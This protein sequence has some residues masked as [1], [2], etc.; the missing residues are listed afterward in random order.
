MSV[1]FFDRHLLLM[2]IYLYICLNLILI[3]YEETI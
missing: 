1:E 2:L 3:Y